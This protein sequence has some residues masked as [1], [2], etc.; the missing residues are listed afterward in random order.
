[1]TLILADLALATLAVYA[2][3]VAS[4]RWYNGT[5]W[6]RCIIEWNYGLSRPVRLTLEGEVKSLPNGDYRFR[7]IRPFAEPVRAIGDWGMGRYEDGDWFDSVLQGTTHVKGRLETSGINW[8]PLPETIAQFN[9]L[10]HELR[11]GVYMNADGSSGYVRCSDF[12]VAE[13]GRL[14]VITA[15]HLIQSA[16]M[17][18]AYVE[19]GLVHLLGEPQQEHVRGK[20]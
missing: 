5:R 16:G 15:G 19:R 13:C 2:T 14:S 18:R 11:D 20:S 8:R 1:M 17:T 4:I 6:R 7:F 9:D 12:H 3:V 10:H